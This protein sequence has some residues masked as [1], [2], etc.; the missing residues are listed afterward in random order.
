MNLHL[1]LLGAGFLS[2]VL[3]A[4]GAPIPRVNLVALGLALVTLAQLL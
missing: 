1:G 4:A 3:A 2:F